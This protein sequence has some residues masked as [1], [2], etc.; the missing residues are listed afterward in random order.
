MPKTLVAVAH[1]RVQGVGYRAYAIEQARAR[2]LVGWVRNRP[3]GS[4]EVEAQGEDEALDGL[5]SALERGPALSFVTRV[6]VVFTERSAYH[7]FDVR[8]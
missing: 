6:D 2:R 7:N 1:G 3:D 8:W 5:V 4:V